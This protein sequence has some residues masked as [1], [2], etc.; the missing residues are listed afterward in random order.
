MRQHQACMAPPIVR[1]RLRVPSKSH[2]EETHEVGGWYREGHGAATCDC[3]AF[4]FRRHCSH[5]T[6]TREVCGWAAVLGAEVQT[7]AQRH[8]HICPRCGGVTE[9]RAF[10]PEASS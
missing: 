3:K 5:L 1:W 7:W 10:L 2:P 9:W 4:Q 8:D 6:V